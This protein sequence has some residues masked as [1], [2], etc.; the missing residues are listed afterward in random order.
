MPAG[1]INPASRAAAVDTL[2]S[3]LERA[4][5]I[6]G[7]RRAF[8]LA[9]LIISRARATVILRRSASLSA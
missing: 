3:S 1:C 5:S 7:D 6:P 8:S 4:A 9:S 2:A